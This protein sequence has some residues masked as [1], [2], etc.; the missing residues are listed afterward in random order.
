LN[1]ADLCLFDDDLM[2]EG[3]RWA[4]KRAKGQDFEAERN[5]WEQQ[6]K[7]AFARFNGPVRVNAANEF[8]DYPGDWP[9]APLGSWNV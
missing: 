9:N 1:D 5:D 4:Y 8:G 2:I 6:V 3:M 7:S